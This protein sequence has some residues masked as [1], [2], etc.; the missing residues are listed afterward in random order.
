MLEPNKSGQAEAA[1]VMPVSLP[2]K[3]WVFP[4]EVE[5]SADLLAACGGSATLARVLIRRGLT[6]AAAVRQFLNESEYVPTAPFELPGVEKAVERMSAAIAKGE[7]I[8]VY[9]DY[10][11][12][13]ITGTSVLLSVLRSLNANV[14]FY[15][16][17][18][19]SEAMV[20]I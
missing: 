12:D 4:Q 19:S 5:P 8:T 9:G 7:K 17:N 3:L 6:T 10:D 11:V 13:G 20:L 1:M 18:R 16:P 14:D 2:A 15:I